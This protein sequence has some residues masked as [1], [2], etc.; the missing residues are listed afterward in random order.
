MEMSIAAD[1]PNLT[2]EE[3]NDLWYDALDGWSTAKTVEGK[4]R[5]WTRYD[6]KVF[7]RQSNNTYWSYSREVPLT[8][9][10]GEIGDVERNWQC[11]PHTEQVTVYRNKP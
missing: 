7:L 8:E 3:L 1:I 10:S 6:T 9:T 4:G 2:Q 11:W 5:R